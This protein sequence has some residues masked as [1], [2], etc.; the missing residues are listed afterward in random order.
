MKTNRNTSFLIASIALIGIQAA[1][2][3]ITYTGRDFGTFTGTSAQSSP[4][5]T[6]SISSDFGWAAATDDNY[7]DS[8]RTRAF[9]FQ[10]AS[11]GIVTLTVQSNASGFLPAFSIFSGLAHISPSLADHDATQISLDYLATLSGP[12]KVGAFFA[13]GDWKVGN[14]PVYNTSGVPSS[15]VSVPA[16]LSSFTY[17]GNAADGTTA[18]F[19]LASGIN[20]DG[21]ADGFVTGTFSLPAGNY[22]IFIGGASLAN[23]GPP[24]VSGSYTNYSAT[25]TLS[26]IPEP[27]S[28]LLIGLSSIGLLVWCRQRH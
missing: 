11:A 24:P 1:S 20:G 4:S 18:N 13:L 5:L 28:A 3:H 2:A 8:H 25:A 17:Q 12:D 26:V 22:S 27:T 10:L 23:E 15:G 6:T 9:R 19:G 14:D 7:G 21:T 16:S